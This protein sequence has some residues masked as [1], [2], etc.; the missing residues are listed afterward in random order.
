MWQCQFR[1]NRSQRAAALTQGLNSGLFATREY[2]HERNV[3]LPSQPG[4]LTLASVCAPQ[5]LNLID[6]DY[7]PSTR[8]SSMKG[9]SIQHSTKTRSPIIRSSK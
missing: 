4:K 1:P 3:G 8:G 6:E 9:D 2:K 7:R 5:Q